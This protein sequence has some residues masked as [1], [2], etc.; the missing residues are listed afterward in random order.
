MRLDESLRVEVNGQVKTLLVLRKEGT[1]NIFE[2]HSI[3]D[4]FNSEYGTN[5]NIISN[6]IADIAL[7]GLWRTLPGFPVDTAIAYEKPGTRFGK[8]VVFST[9]NQSKVV[10]ATGKYEGEKDIALVALGLNSAYFKKK[11]NSI[12]LEI[13]E[14]QIIPVSNFPA[15]NGWYCFHPETG[16][17]CGQKAEARDIRYLWRE[18]N[19]YVGLIARGINYYDWCDIVWTNCLP[20]TKLG[21]VAEVPESEI[22]TIKSLA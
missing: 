9:K 15:A 8:E 11:R 13:P 18:N 16:V 22:S 7:S 19:S 5:L 1:T 14:T 10:M 12:L 6:K 2:A 4:K 17:P 21:V 20:S 3:V